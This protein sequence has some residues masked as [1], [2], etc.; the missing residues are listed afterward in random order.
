MADILTLVMEDADPDTLQGFHYGT[1]HSQPTYQPVVDATSL[2]TGVTL[3]NKD[4]LILRIVRDPFSPPVNLLQGKSIALECVNGMTVACAKLQY[5][6]N[7]PFDVARAEIL[8][9]LNRQRQN[10]A[11]AGMMPPGSAP[12]LRGSD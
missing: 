9:R 12:N 3:T 1:R 4:N 5:A 6:E 11:F 7:V 10:E 2:T 8:H